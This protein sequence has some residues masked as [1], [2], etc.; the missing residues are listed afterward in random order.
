VAAKDLGGVGEA[1][2][3]DLFGVVKAFGGPVKAADEGVAVCCAA[4]AEEHRVQAGRVI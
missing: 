2:A 4:D 3:Q 1:D